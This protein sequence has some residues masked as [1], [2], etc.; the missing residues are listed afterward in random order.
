M[1][2][3][4]AW[5]QFLRRL[6]KEGQDA[7]F[8]AS[9]VRA[10]ATG[11]YPSE[12]QAKWQTAR[13]YPPLN[14][15]AHELVFIDNPDGTVDVQPSE[16]KRGAKGQGGHNYVAT[17]DPSLAALQPLIEAVDPAKEASG[18][19]EM[20][21]VYHNM[22]TPWDAIDPE[23]VPSIGALGYLKWAKEDAKNTSK[24]YEL[25][26]KSL[27]KRGIADEDARRRDDGRK[28]FSLLEKFEGSLGDTETASA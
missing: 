7:Q 1:D 28:T 10:A 13:K 8:K 21:W 3:R 16:G 11:N 25:W 18:Q 5:R 17:Y 23:K 22:L 15:S 6:N 9:W 12:Q 27:E 14:G 19:E 20:R 24:F 4:E 2:R 26:T